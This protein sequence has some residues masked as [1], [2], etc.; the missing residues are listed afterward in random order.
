MYKAR[1]TLGKEGE[2]TN[3]L[4]FIDDSKLC[5]K[6]ESEL[7][8]LALIEN[9]D[10]PPLCKMCG[11]KRR[12][13]CSKMAQMDYRHRHEVARIIL[14]GHLKKTYIRNEGQVL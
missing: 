2:S 3:H 6:D 11:E 8:S 12:D 14:F 13:R 10:V 9:Q 5:G 1:Y 4:L 7:D